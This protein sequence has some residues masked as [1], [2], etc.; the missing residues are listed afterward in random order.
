MQASK[1][2]LVPSQEGPRGRGSSHRIPFNPIA[3]GRAQNS[4]SFAREGSR[5]QGRGGCPK[6]AA[7]APNSAPQYTADMSRRNWAAPVP[8]LPP[9]A[10]KTED[11]SFLATDAQVRECWRGC[12]AG[13]GTG[14]RNRGRVP[15][16]AANELPFWQQTARIRANLRG[17]S[18]HQRLTNGSNEVFISI[19]IKELYS[20]ISV[21]QASRPNRLAPLL[22]PPARLGR[23]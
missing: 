15:D 16:M 17:L 18:Q 2:K 9:P 5:G 11:S 22:L 21:F 6:P 7:T 3:G 4:V 23:I 12:V 8:Q 10:R 19:L 13:A 14:Q 20:Y 1:Q